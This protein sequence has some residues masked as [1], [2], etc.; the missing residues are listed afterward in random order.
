M[1]VGVLGGGQLGRMIAL[2]GY[3]L[4]ITCRFLEPA[5]EA[6]AAQVGERVQGEFEDYQALYRFAEGL[7]LVTFEFENVPVASARWLAERLPVY[8][9]PDALAVAQDRIDEK[10]FFQRLGIPTPP[11]APVSSRA[12]FDE[13]LARIGRP[14]V[15]KTTRFGYDGKGQTVIRTAH[16]AEESW[17]LLGGR[18]LILE[19]FVP[20]DRELSIVAVRGRDGG[21]AFYP[22]VENT[23]RDGML[24]FTR[25]PATRLDPNLRRAA[26]EYASAC[27]DALNYVGVIAIELFEAGGRLLVNEMA[28]RVHNSGHWTTEGAETSQ[29]ENHL[30]AVCGLPLGGTAAVGESAMLNLIGTLPNIDEVLAVTGAHP[31]LYGKRPRPNRKLGHVTVRAEDD[32][33]LERRL[34]RVRTAVGISGA[35]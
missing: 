20:F 15:L 14:A 31:H 21:R 18:P 10:S 35:T 27:L 23:H 6:S 26:E 13:A 17:E 8:P 32:A 12:D 9:T 33:E 34:K 7:D 1:N 16:D 3:P 29:F 2:A 11:F 28:P 30:R 5:G 22:I 25:A 4:G 19:G 24:R